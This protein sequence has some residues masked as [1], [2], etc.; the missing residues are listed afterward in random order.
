MSR[1][2][3]N[4]IMD[5]NR[6][7]HQSAI[8]LYTASQI[9]SDEHSYANRWRRLSERRLTICIIHKLSA[10]Q[11]E[12]SGDVQYT[13]LQYVTVHRMPKFTSCHNAIMVVTGRAYCIYIYIYIYIYIFKLNKIYL[14]SRHY[15]TSSNC[16]FI[17]LQG[18]VF[19]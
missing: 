3:H 17:Q 19:I 7:G 5:C 4:A 1:V 10:Q 16:I 8:L 9:H 12:H 2:T 11:N 15:F 14:H 18:I 13:I 6:G